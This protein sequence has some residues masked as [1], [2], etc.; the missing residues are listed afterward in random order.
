MSGDGGDELFG[1]YPWRYYRAVNNSNFE[2]YIDKYFDFW[3]R[4][5]PSDTYHKLFSPIWHNVSDF[6]P[7]EILQHI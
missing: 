2:N 3:Q 4:L 7:K 6:D 1:G 5:I